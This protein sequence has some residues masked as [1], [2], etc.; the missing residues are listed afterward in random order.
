[1]NYGRLRAGGALLASALLLAACSSEP[2]DDLAFKEI[3]AEKSYNEGLAY[4]KAGNYREATAK[5]EEVDQQHPYSE[6]AR[7]SLIMTAYTNY[8]RGNFD[9]CVS[10]AQRYT[11]L[12]PGSEDAAYA[13]FLIGQS[14]FHQMPDIY[15]D[16]E[17]TRKAMQAMTEVTQRYPESA[18]AAEAQRKVDITRDQLAGKEMEIGRYYLGQLNFVAAI[19]RFKTVVT[20]YQTTRHTEEALERLTE[21]YFA[22][23]VVSEAQTAAAVLGHNY[24]ESRWYRDAYNLLQTKG[25]EPREDSSSWISRAFRGVIG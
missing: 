7:K 24:P 15:R 19:N 16:Q 6:W 2:V 8:T 12:Y 20:D 21:A 18:Y 3:P 17:M 1:M 9:E 4:L 13:Q 22:M 10:S 11:T 23:G 5:F 25:L 14:Y